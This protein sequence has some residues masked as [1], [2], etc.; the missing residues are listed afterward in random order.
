M[1]DQMLLLS[2]LLILMISI[3]VQNPF[4]RISGFLTSF[5]LMTLAVTKDIT[6]ILVIMTIGLVI[7]VLLLLSYKEYTKN[8]DQL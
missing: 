3:V 4:Y 6:S 8:D 5:C 1:S 2:S 7:H